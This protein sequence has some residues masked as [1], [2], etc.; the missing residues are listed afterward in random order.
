[1]QRWDASAGY[2]Q[3]CLLLP[4]YL[5]E[6]K[7]HKLGHGITKQT[8]QSSGHTEGI[9]QFIQGLG[10]LRGENTIKIV[11]TVPSVT[12]PPRKV[13][14]A[15]KGRIKDKLDPMEEAG[16]IV[17]QTEPT[18]WVSGMATIIIIKN[19]NQNLHCFK[20]SELDSKA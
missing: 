1:M 15:L 10:C 2:L 7:Q 14:V 18:S 17:K 9:P 3:F 20:T 12:H 5:T 4:K 11:P 13:P 8:V 19:Q 6:L 16:V